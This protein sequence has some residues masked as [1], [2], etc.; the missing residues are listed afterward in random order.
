MQYLIILS[1][2][3]FIFLAFLN[4][5]NTSI[6]NPFI[7]YIFFILNIIVKYFP[8]F[9]ITFCILF[10]ILIKPYLSRKHINL[11]IV[12]H[13]IFQL[14]SLLIIGIISSFIILMM[15]AF[16]E[17]TIFSLI[18]KQNPSI[19]GVK[20]NSNDILTAIMNNNKP[21][22]IITNDINSQ[23]EV[24]AIAKASSGVN[25]FYGNKILETFP[26]I[27]VM[28]I[29]NNSNLLFLDN[30]LVVKK[31]DENDMNRI[32]PI[33]GYQIIKSYFPERKIKSN[34]K[35]S[36]LNKNSYDEYRKIDVKE[37]LSRVDNEILKTERAISSFSAE[38]EILT[39]LKNQNEIDRKNILK[40]K[41]TQ[42]NKCLSEGTY[43][44]NVFTPIN[45]EDFCL[46]LTK[47]W[48]DEFKTKDAEG[49]RLTT[50]IT[51]KDKIL[52]DY[53][54]YNTYFKSQKILID[55]SSGNIPSELGVFEPTDKI[56]IIVSDTSST[57]IADF[58]ESLS[59]EYLH[60]TSY[61][62]NK[63]L[64]SSFFEEALTE[65]FARLAIKSSLKT[66]TN[67]GYPAHIKIIEQMNKNIS[68]P[69]L[70]DIYFNKD[71]DEL[72]KKINL[73]Y[74]DDFYNKNIILFESLQY[75]SDKTQVLQIVNRIM[76]KLGGNPLQEN[77]IFS[78]ESRI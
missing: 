58:F 71:Q 4:N 41:D 25:N 23:N 47:N 75:T 34:P 12:A 11:K 53:I 15:I 31:I 18:L 32:S 52:K 7:A 59:H 73:V 72:E 48:D 42:Y 43:T 57:S 35:I 60:F 2:I 20:T 46:E 9:L 37:K 24:I 27:L 44:A 78:K 6:S 70:A 68:E 17:L 77:E 61:S 67:L 49:E 10:I 3:F 69:D 50:T 21:P 33:I 5:T 13:T 55:A 38:I 64:E 39:N 30:T 36:V 14:F 8:Y 40:S 76:E 28:P 62:P 22:E 54:F 29:K 65:Y 74:G 19:L 16:L 51:E 56:K 63:K 45:T 26:K 66:D 1:T